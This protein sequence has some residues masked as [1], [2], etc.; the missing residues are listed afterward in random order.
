MTYTDAELD[1]IARRFMEGLEKDFQDL[2][3]PIS[4]DRLE[5]GLNCFLAGAKMVNN[6]KGY[7]EV[8]GL[9]T[10][11]QQTEDSAYGVFK[12]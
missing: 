1:E 3:A 12:P 11:Q 2:G 4:K 5:F 7:L 9:S 8:H 6:H 10:E